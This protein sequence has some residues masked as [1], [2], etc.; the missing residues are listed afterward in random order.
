ME[1]NKKELTIAIDGPAGSGKST[2]AKILAK[3][4]NLLYLDTGAMYRAIALAWVNHLTANKMDLEEYINDKAKNNE[5]LTQIMNSNKVDLIQKGENLS[6]LLN[7]EDVSSQIRDIIITK[8]SSPISAYPVVREKLID[9]QRELGKRGGVVMDGR[10]IG[11]VVFP[12]AELKVFLIADID[13]RTE[14]RYKELQAK[15]VEIDKDDLKKQIAERDYNDSNRDASPL[16]RAEDALELDTS[17]MSFEEQIE[18][19]LEL[20]NA[21]IAE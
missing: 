7:G 2:I 1:N 8:Y 3:K 10:D 16:K 12:N 18:K 21:K 5:I 20:V 17:N 15:G 14:R 4:Y 9:Q 13:S 6:I 19:L 11:T